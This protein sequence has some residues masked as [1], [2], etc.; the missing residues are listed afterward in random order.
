MVQSVTRSLLLLQTLGQAHKKCSLTELCETTNLAP[1]TIHRLLLT[2]K[3]SRFISQDPASAKYF[4]GPALITLGIRASNYL[5][6]RELARPILA[7][8]AANSKEDAYLSLIDGESAIM[9]ESAYG[10]QPLKVIYPLTS[11]I[12]LHSGAARKVLLAYQEPNFIQNYLTK[13]LFKYTENTTTDAKKLQLQL[14]E[15]RKNGYSVTIGE[16]FNGALGICSPVL[17]SFGHIAAGIGL[18][19]PRVRVTEA[20]TPDLI[21]LVK[22]HAQ[23]LSTALGYVAKE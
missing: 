16:S 22:E 10:P 8:L 18:S 6:L 17:D 13:E 19:C 20:D 11:A 5:N 3:E 1:S 15:I 4:L 12:P 7:D 23:Q 14:E 9:A 21:K 2:L